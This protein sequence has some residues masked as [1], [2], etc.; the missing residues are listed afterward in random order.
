MFVEAGGNLIDTAAGYGDG[1]SERLIGSLVGDVVKRD[2]VVIA[3]KAGISRSGGERVTDASRGF[4]LRSLDAS[5]ERLGVDHV[6][7]FQVHTWVDDTPLEETLSALDLAVSSGRGGVRRHLELLRMADGAGRDLAVGRP[8]PGPDRLDPGRV[9]P[10]EPVGRARDHRRRTGAG[11]RRTPLVPAGQGR[12]D[13]QVPLRQPRPTPAQ[14]RRTSPTSSAST[15]P[16]PSAAS[17]R[18][19][20]ARPRGWAGRRWR[21]PSPGSATN[22]A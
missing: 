3:T 21:S 14:R 9:L 6:D 12:P 18:P 1:D 20:S 7:L 4:L 22:R 17:S 13:R 15:S 10:A 2:D 8:G 5:L 19:S 11:G 16:T